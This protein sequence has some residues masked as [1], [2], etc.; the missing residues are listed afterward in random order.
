MRLGIVHVPYDSGHRERRTG[1]GPGALIEV[2][3]IP[4]LRARGHDVVFSEV[5]APLEV[6]T[7]TAAALALQPQIADAVRGMV[8]AGRL[9]VI[10]SGSC[11]LA[12]LG[13]L[14]GLAYH[15]L[16]GP[17]LGVAWLDAHGDLNTPETS[18]SGFFDGMALALLTGRCWRPLMAR[19]EGVEPLGDDQVALIG[20]RDLDPAEHAL[21]REAQI[22]H[23]RPSELDLLVTIW[24]HWAVAD[25]RLYLHI[26]LDVLDPAVLRANPWA[27]PGGLELAQLVGLVERAA[28]R[29]PVAAIAFTAFDPDCGAPEIAAGVVLAC[30]DALG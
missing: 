8:A 28:A 14:G 5:D 27:A 2:G 26:D 1:R 7:D 19:F 23:V 30:L 24:D 18:A 20:A 16:G 15:G 21:L 4:K 17:G 3:L 25:R 13:A 10:L 22:A 29:L 9:P 6:P 11:H 12:A